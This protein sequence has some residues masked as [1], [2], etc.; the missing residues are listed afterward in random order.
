MPQ[1][2]SVIER[3]VTAWEPMTIEEAMDG[4]AENPRDPAVE[5]DRLDPGPCDDELRFVVDWA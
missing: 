4:L 5:Q 1:Q 3:T 2:S